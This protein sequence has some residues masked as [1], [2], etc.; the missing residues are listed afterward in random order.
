MSLV[1][2]LEGRLW[3]PARESCITPFL[4]AAYS[5]CESVRQRKSGAKNLEAIAL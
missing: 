3:E 1:S 5:G 4:L 2:G